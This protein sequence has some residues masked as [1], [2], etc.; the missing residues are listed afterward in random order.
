LLLVASVRVLL[1]GWLR[2]DWFRRWAVVRRRRRGD[3]WHP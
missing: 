2:V 1:A 3:F